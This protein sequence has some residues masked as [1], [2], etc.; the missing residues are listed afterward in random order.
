MVVYVTMETIVCNLL[1]ITDTALLNNVGTVG[2]LIL[3]RTSCLCF[4]LRFE[5]LHYVPVSG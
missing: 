3:S 1:F 2:D 5:S 4:M